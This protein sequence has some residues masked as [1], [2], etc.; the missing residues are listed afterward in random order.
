LA[1]SFLLAESIVHGLTLINN[2]PMQYL[3]YLSQIGISMSPLSENSLYVKYAQNP[4]HPLFQR[5]LNVTLSSDNPLQLHLTEEPLAE[6]Y[7]IATQMFRLSN[8]DYAEIARNRFFFLNLIF[9][10]K[11]N[12]TKKSKKKYPYF[13]ISSL[14]ETKMVGR[15]LSPSRYNRKRYQQD[16]YFQHTSQFQKRTS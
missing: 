2:P 9:F 4:F 13:R 12:K 6:E 7:A 10:S 8:T 5:G 16:K 3:Y 1:S 14:H 11:N 15:K